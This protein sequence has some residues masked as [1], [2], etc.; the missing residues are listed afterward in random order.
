MEE[1]S[2]GKKE[3]ATKYLQNKDANRNLAM[4]G[5]SGGFIHQKLQYLCPKQ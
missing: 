4:K 3:N 1:R 5:I 2:F